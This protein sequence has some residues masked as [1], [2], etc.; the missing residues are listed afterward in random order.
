MYIGILYI[1]F[2]YILWPL[3]W[4]SKDLVSLSLGMATPERKCF[5]LV[6][7]VGSAMVALASLS[8]LLLLVVV[9]KNLQFPFADGKFLD[10]VGS[11]DLKQCGLGFACGAVAPLL[12]S[13]QIVNGLGNGACLV[14]DNE[15]FRAGHKQSQEKN[16]K[17]VWKCAHDKLLTQTA[18]PKETS[19]MKN[20]L[21]SKVHSCFQVCSQK[22]LSG[23]TACLESRKTQC[24]QEAET[25]C[26]QPMLHLQHDAFA[27]ALKTCGYHP[28]T[29]SLWDTLWGVG[30]TIACNMLGEQ[31]VQ[32]FMTEAAEEE[33]KEN[34]DP[35]GADCRAE[36]G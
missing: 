2:S 14:A 8:S 20:C 27:K 33:G 25:A 28:H 10:G 4:A 23:Q 17:H 5:P 32:K 31:L 1:L 34:F 11:K 29:T 3:W 15:A 19:S 22:A 13:S 35:C 6:A 18:P 24:A 9:A 7:S 16:N 21:R 30:E 36:G 12:S 26:K